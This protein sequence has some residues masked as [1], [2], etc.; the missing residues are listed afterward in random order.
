MMA[1]ECCNG[2]PTSELEERQFEIDQFIS[3][4]LIKAN[5]KFN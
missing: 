5:V 2:M 3:N 1:S 4:K